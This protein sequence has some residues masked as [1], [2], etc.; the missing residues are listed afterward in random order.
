MTSWLELLLH[1]SWLTWV[2][3]RPQTRWAPGLLQRAT[4]PPLSPPQAV[5]TA[6]ALCQP[7]LGEGNMTEGERGE[8]IHPV[9]CT[10]SSHP[11]CHPLSHTAALTPA[12]RGAVCLSFHLR[13]TLHTEGSK[14]GER[15]GGT[16]PGKLKSS[17]SLLNGMAVAC[18]MYLNPWGR[19]RESGSA[20]KMR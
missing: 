1:C 8:E 6:G 2:D 5:A 13:D 3:W 18:G 9:L 19:R 12:L 15:G 20:H 10:S 14:T 11:A 4:M 7:L 17:W 16:Y